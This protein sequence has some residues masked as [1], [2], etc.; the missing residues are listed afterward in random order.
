[1]F[2]QILM[3]I[4]AFFMFVAAL[5][6]ARMPDL[7]MRL[8]SN[9]KSATFGVGFLL[10]GAAIHFW[11]FAISIRALAILIFLFATSPVA[12]HML[13]RAAYIAGAPLW[14]GT[15]SDDLKG[16]YDYKTHELTA[17]P[18]EQQPKPRKTG[19]KRTK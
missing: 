15:L 7:F 13:G 6:V 16:Q 18:E 9:T 17:Q 4:G 19:E 5:G 12:A 1:M 14:K 3:F 2:A 11:E 10:L 8:Q